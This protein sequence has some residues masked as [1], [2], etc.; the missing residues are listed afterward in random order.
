M[1][2]AKNA[3]NT[4]LIIRLDFSDT[5][6]AD[7]GNTTY[8]GGEYRIDGE[9]CQAWGDDRSDSWHVEAAEKIEGKIQAK[10]PD[11]KLWQAR[12]SKTNRKAWLAWKPGKS[13]PEKNLLLDLTNLVVDLTNQR[14][15][16]A[17]LEVI[18]SKDR[19]FTATL[20]RFQ[21]KSRNKFGSLSTKVK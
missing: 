3:G 21:E 10:W 9:A 6:D 18:R 17:N 19:V 11:F 12:A 4:M 7:D 14:T 15:K 1:S 13:S 20:K 16:R 8:Y 5:Q 2:D